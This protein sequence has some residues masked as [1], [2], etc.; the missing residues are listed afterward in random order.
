M[1]SSVNILRE[2]FPNDN[3]EESP[4]PTNHY[5]LQQLQLGNF[6]SLLDQ[7]GYPYAWAQRICG[8]DF[9]GYKV[10]GSCVLFITEC[11]ISLL[12][13]LEENISVCLFICSIYLAWQ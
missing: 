10:T 4:N 6:S 7:L 9:I 11:N 12:Q 8:L 3:G 2:L 1:L 13:S 5:Q